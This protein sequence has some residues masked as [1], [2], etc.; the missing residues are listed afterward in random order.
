[1][2]SFSSIKHRPG[3]AVCLRQIFDAAFWREARSARIPEGSRWTLS[4]LAYTWIT[5]ALSNERSL[6]DRFEYAR[7]W[8]VN[9]FIKLRRPGTSF[10]GFIDAS[11]AYA[12]ALLPKLRERMRYLAARRPKKQ[13]YAWPVF[14]VDGSHLRLPHTRANAHKF[15]RTRIKNRADSAPQLLVVS[16]VS[17]QNCSLQDWEIA[18]GNDSEPELTAA[19]IKRLPAEALVVKDAGAVG[20]QWFKELLEGG[21]HILMRVGAN[22][23]VWAEQVGVTRCAG[24]GVWLYPKRV[25]QQPPLRFRL[26]AVRVPRQ[27]RKNAKPGKGLR[28]KTIYLLTDLKATELSDQEAGHLYRLR[29]RASEIGFRSFKQTLGHTAL[30]A[31]TPALALCECHFALLGLQVLTLLALWASPVA[32]KYR[33]SVAQAWRTWRKTIRHNL[34]YKVLLAL[35]AKCTLDNY[36]RCKAKIRR[37]VPQKKRFDKICP[38]KFRKLTNEIKERWAK[39]FGV[40]FTFNF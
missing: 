32:D 2:P 29:W 27:K 30:L 40:T 34:T 16:A 19:I 36:H 15:G 39:A 8:L 10:Q 4:L 1:M 12:E 22:F 28:F 11:R 5:M 25:G 24:G 33:Q 13:S 3:L 14:A 6:R 20:Y 7:N 21:R 26:I 18:G 31:R 17:L 38:P 35:L 9:T 37:R 23:Q